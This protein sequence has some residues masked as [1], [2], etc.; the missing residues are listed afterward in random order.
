LWLDLCDN[1]KLTSHNTFYILSCF[2]IYELSLNLN[3]VFSILTINVEKYAQVVNFVLKILLLS[4]IVLF[5][6]VFIMLSPIHRF[7]MHKMRTCKMF[8]LPCLALNLLSILLLRC[9]LLL[10]LRSGGCACNYHFTELLDF[11]LLRLI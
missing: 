6:C 2:I 4:G 5:I 8:A 3:A 11:Y 10:L 7:S 1:Y 9:L